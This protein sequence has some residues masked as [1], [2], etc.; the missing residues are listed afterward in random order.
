MKEKRR[1]NIQGPV[2]HEEGRV[3]EGSVTEIMRTGRQMTWDSS[4]EEL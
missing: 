2:F 1:Q 3:T 4:D